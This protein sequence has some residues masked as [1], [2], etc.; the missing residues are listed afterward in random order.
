MARWLRRGMRWRE[1][2]SL[3]MMLAY[4]ERGTILGQMRKR[5]SRE[6]VLSRLREGGNAVIVIV[7]LKPI[8]TLHQELLR[9]Q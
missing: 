1:R 2:G 5:M 6:E 3:K 8:S 4:C 7:F 9:K